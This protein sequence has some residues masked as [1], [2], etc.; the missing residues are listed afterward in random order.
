[1]CISKQYNYKENHNNLK[2]QMDALNERHTVLMGILDAFNGENPIPINYNQLLKFPLF[3]WV[4]LNDK[5]SIQRRNMLFKDHLNF[6]TT[7]LEGGEFGKHFHDDVIENCEILKGSLRDDEDGSIYKTGD[8]M[9][10]EK[11]QH[12]KP[13]AL[14]DSVLR[15]IFKPCNNENY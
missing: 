10:Y 13:I 1:M 4:K 3:E 15:V 5:V 2:M 12:H 6:D 14:E 9:H 7:I 8:V 11:G